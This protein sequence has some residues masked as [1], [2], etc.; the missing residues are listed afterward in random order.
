[1]LIDFETKTEVLHQYRNLQGLHY[2]DLHS[3]S[4]RTSV[5]SKFADQGAVLLMNNCLNHIAEE[6]LNLFSSTHVPVIMTM[7]IIMIIMIIIT[8]A[9]L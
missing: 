2:A 9:I 8:F 4:Q 1:V 5:E 6:I 7:I 3:L